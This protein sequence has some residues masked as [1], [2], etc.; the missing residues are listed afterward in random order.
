MGGQKYGCF[1]NFFNAPFVF[2]MPKEFAGC[3]LTDDERMVECGFSEKAIMLCK[4]AAMG[5]RVGYLQIAASEADPYQ[6]KKMGRQVKGFSDDIWKRIECSVAFSVVYQKFSQLDV[7]QEILLSTEDWVLVEATKND[8]NWGSGL[9]KGDPNNHIP[10]K[11]Q[12][13]NMLGWALMEARTA[14]RKGVIDGGATCG[15]LPASPAT[16]PPAASSLGADEK[17]FMKV[18]KKVREIVKL[19][20]DVCSG[21]T[22]DNMQLSKVQGKRGVCEEFLRLW[23]CLPDG[24]D[25]RHKNEKLFAIVHEFV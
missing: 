1:S 15:I 14:I 17:T 18:A 11:W 8:S 25:L 22:L 6:I 16:P 24:S 20:E 10:R 23:S 19:E 21:K 9:D 4:A 3:P 12:G 2:T 13:T 7:Q 5:D